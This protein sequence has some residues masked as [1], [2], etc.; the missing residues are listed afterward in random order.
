MRA[1]ESHRVQAKKVTRR[2]G[3]HRETAQL[4]A[5][6]L[7]VREGSLAS[8]ETARLIL[9]FSTQVRT[10]WSVAIAKVHNEQGER[11]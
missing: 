1:K 5:T 10:I 9:K 8:S 11:I 2:H 3:R 7:W 4:S 6:K